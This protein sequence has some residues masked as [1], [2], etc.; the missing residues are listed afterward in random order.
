M[1][2]LSRLCI[3][4]VTLNE[5]CDFG[6]AV[7]CLARNGV[8][9]T[10]PW[11]AKV[12]EIGVSAA[13]KLLDDA[14]VSAVSLAPGAGLTGIGEE[15]GRAGIDENRRLID[16]A[17][18]LGAA[19]L[20][21][22]TGGLPEGDHDLDGARKRAFDRLAELAPHARAAGV[23][24]ALEPLHPMVCGFRS[25]ICSVSEANDWLDQLDAPDVFGIAIDSYAVWWEGGLAGEIERAGERIANVHI[26]DWLRDT[27]DVRLDR[28][29]MG[30]GIIDNRLFCRRID[31]TGFSGPIE[32]EIFS[33]RNWWQRDPDEV[34]ETIKTRFAEHVL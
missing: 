27:S 32:V 7:D 29:M 10:A 11:V 2:D 6:A 34:V 26:S 17:A 9:Q 30:D 24:L 16:M 3:H 5:R 19:S 25:V 23:R 22:L 8:M 15:A 28:G 14:G 1:T 21:T 12:D 20:V 13:R 4:M 18:E 33:A 31:A